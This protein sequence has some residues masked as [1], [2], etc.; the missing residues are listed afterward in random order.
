MEIGLHGWSDGVGFCI[1]HQIAVS[2]GFDKH[3]VVEITEAGDALVIR[4]K[5]LPAL[6]DL[7]ISIPENF[8][9]PKDVQDFVDGEPIGQEMI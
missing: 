1:P 7:L 4:K 9:Y 5:K 6:D 2:L 8:Q 3:S